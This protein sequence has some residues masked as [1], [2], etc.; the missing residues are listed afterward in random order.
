MSSSR[1][2]IEDIGELILKIGKL[3]SF[4]FKLRN[5]GK[6]CKFKNGDY[7]I[8][9][10]CFTVHELNSVNYAHLKKYKTGVNYDGMVYCVELE[11]NHI[12]YVRRNGKCTWCGNCRSYLEPVY[13]WD[14]SPRY[15]SSDKFTSSIPDEFQSSPAGF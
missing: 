4:N 15:N 6:V 11:Q 12:L 9:H 10:P 7:I 2:L 5:L 13:A 8:N 3:P 14:D 1:Q